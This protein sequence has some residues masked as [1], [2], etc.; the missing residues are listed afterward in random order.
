[1]TFLGFLE[2]VPT[3]LNGIDLF[4]L[5][6]LRE[7]FSLATVQALASSLP[8]AATRS[9]GP[10]EIIEEGV[11][12]VLVEPRSVTALSE[13]IC[14]MARDPVRRAT[15]AA[16]EQRRAIAA[17]SVEAMVRSYERLYSAVVAR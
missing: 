6:S 7:G 15:F 4:V 17:F 9:G 12:G 8:V 3:F 14:S 11:S 10:E 1:M 2:D 5:P 16:A 13:A